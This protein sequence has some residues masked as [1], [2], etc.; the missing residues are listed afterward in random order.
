MRTIVITGVSSGLGEAIAAE[1]LKR[2]NRVVGTLRSE[3]QRAAFDA[4]VPGRSFG[5]L[6]DVTETAAIAPFVEEVER[7]IGPIDALVNNTGYGLRGVLE[8]LDLGDVRKQL[9][10]NLLG[11][12][13]L[14]QAVLPAMRARGAGHILNMASMGSFITFP[15]LGAYHMSKF[16]LL[17][18][19]DTLAKEV[20]PLGIKVT[21]IMPGLFNTDWSGRSQAHAEHHIADYDAL[22]SRDAP[23]MRGDPAALADVVLQAIEMDQPPAHLLIGPS[24]V[25][26][27]RERLSLWSGEID[28]WATLSEST[29]E[30]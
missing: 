18:L 4:K 12:L 10:V 20:T 21:A 25:D 9:E 2:G 1:A 26:N 23:P 3:E 5:R 28:R 8:E 22:L 16:A 7:T 14:T 15:S 17:G 13:A 27:M 11:P 6:L 24:A 30:G 19:S 29:G